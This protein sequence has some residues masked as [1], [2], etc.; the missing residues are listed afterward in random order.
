MKSKHIEN[1]TRF[2]W[3]GQAYKLKQGPY[4]GSLC[5]VNVEHDEDT[6]IQFE[7]SD[8]SSISWNVATDGERVY[9]TIYQESAGNF[10]FTHGPIRIRSPLAPCSTP[11]EAILQVC[12]LVLSGIVY[13]K[14]VS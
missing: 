9:G 14:G 7:P 12:K 11:I 4:K 13:V 2:I 5:L 8:S 3:N 10:Q 1:L 6:L